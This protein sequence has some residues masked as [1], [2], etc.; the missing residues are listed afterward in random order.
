MHKTTVLVSNEPRAYREAI[1]S[2]LQM[3]CPHAEIVV[4]GD[5][6]GDDLDAAVA[7]VRPDMVICNRATA[8]ARTARA[9]IELYP[10]GARSATVGVSGACDAVPGIDLG[11]LATLIDRI[12]ADVG[13]NSPTRM[14]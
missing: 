1:A 11:A 13:P 5:D 4:R 12:A 10:D 9:W 14:E 6:L 3:L 8:L 2:A 7:A